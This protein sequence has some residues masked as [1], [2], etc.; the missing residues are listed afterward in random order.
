MMASHTCAR[1]LQVSVCDLLQEREAAEAQ[2]ELERRA[3]ESAA[4]DEEARQL[5]EEL[6]RTRLEMEEKQRALQEALTTPP[7]LH[8][9]DHDDEDEDSHSHSMIIRHATQ[10][11]NC[12][13]LDFT[14]QLVATLPTNTAIPNP[15]YTS[16]PA[17][18]YIYAHCLFRLLFL[19]IISTAYHLLSGSRAA[20]LLLN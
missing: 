5:E 20:R 3:A 16:L 1:L 4:K 6:R 19:S 7:Q 13:S 12:G 8:V 10:W 11:L 18:V 15:L 14:G 17:P 2:A 9:H